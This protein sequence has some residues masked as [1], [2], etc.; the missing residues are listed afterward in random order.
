MT[1]EEEFLGKQ[2]AYC[3]R[4]GGS[5]DDG[6]VNE[7]KVKLVVHV[8]S[9][10]I[11]T[12]REALHSNTQFEDPHNTRKWHGLTKS[13]ALSVFSFLLSITCVFKIIIHRMQ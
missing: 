3:L 12:A 13:K 5:H 2:C 1:G 11:L 9:D 4:V 10:H 7:D 6:E 8:C